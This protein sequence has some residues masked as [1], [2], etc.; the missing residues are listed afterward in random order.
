MSTLCSQVHRA[1]RVAGEKESRYDKQQEGQQVKEDISWKQTVVAAGWPRFL[2]FS[3]ML[4]LLFTL[5]KRLTG[6]PV[7]VPL[8]L[9]IQ[10]SWGITSLSLPR[11][12]YSGSPHSYN[13]RRCSLVVAIIIIEN[14]TYFYEPIF[15]NDRSVK[16]NSIY[17]PSLQFEVIPKVYTTHPRGRWV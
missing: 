15:D 11:H 7:V 3:L 10:P 4:A 9:L 6:L 14:P 5:Y 13:I 17:P 8:R 16:F 1:W 12:C 2:F